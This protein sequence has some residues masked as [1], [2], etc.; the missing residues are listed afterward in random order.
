M[1]FEIKSM[2]SNQ[3]WTLI[4]PLPNTKIVGCKWIYKRKKDCDGK[5]QAYKARLVAKGYTQVERV[6]YEDVLSSVAMLKSIRILLSIA[7][8]YVYEIQQMDVKTVFLNDELDTV[9]YM[10]Q[11]DGF[12]EPDNEYMVCKLQKSIN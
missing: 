6:N 5:E 7:D 9:I 8:H 10:D 2:H 12:I 1:K 4:E 11:L 3:V